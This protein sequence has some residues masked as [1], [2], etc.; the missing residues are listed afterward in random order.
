MRGKL[1]AGGRGARGRDILQAKRQNPSRLF[2]S[3]LGWPCVGTSLGPVWKARGYST[4]TPTAAPRPRLIQPSSQ[5]GSR[6]ELFFYLVVRLAP[7]EAR[8][9]GRRLPAAAS[10]KGKVLCALVGDPGGRRARH[11]TPTAFLRWEANCSPGHAAL[12]RSRGPSLP[13][14]CAEFP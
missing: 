5:N 12:Q 13:L 11:C 7:Q 10:R 8:K 14:V 4:Q 3:R 6:G 9:A 2:S 1:K